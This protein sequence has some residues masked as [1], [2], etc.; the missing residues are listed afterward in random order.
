MTQSSRPKATCKTL[1]EKKNTCKN[2]KFM[3]YC[4]LLFVT[5]CVVIVVV[6]VAVGKNKNSKSRTSAGLIFWFCVPNV[7]KIEKKFNFRQLGKHIQDMRVICDKLLLILF[8]KTGQTSYAGL[9]HG[10]MFLEN[11]SAHTNPQCFS[12]DMIVWRS[13][14]IFILKKQVKHSEVLQKH[15]CCQNILRNCMS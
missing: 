12:P 11:F 10:S 3:R 5:I 2:A 4:M 1:I 15:I 6:N 9:T 14:N 8:H 13:H 7:R